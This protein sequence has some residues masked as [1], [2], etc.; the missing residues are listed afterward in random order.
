MIREVLNGDFM[1][2]S[3]ARKIC[4]QKG[5]RKSEIRA[6][7]AAEG[8]KSV[9]IQN[10]A[11]ERQWLWYFPDDIWKKYEGDKDGKKGD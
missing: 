8:I 4:L 2:C 3:K 9:T 11:G 1:D 10:S 5:F 6:A 7:K